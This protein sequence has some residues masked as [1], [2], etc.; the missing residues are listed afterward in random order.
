MMTLKPFL[1]NMAKPIPAL[2]KRLREILRLYSF[3]ERSSTEQ[4]I[5]GIRDMSC[6][7]VMRRTGA[8]AWRGFCRGTEITLEFDERAYVGSS[9]F[10]FA[11]VLNHFFALYASVNSFTQLTITSTQREGIWKRWPPMAGGQAV[12]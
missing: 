1:R 3:S 11:S 6:E 7:R 2:F 8:D 12:L 4:Q 5:A 9:A 10:L